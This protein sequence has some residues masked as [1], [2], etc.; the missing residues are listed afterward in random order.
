MIKDEEENRVCLFK[1][2]KMI[3]DKELV[4]CWEYKFSEKF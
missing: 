2:K 1:F 4:N 3:K